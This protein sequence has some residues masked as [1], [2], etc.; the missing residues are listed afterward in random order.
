MTSITTPLPVT[1]KIVVLENNEF[2]SVS[3]LRA[4]TEL[5]N[6]TR[7]ILRGNNIATVFASQSGD[8]EDKSTFQFSRTLT[9]LDVSHNK[10]DSWQF[11]N[12]L[13]T[14]FPGLNSLR[15]SGNPLH[16]RAI[17]PTSVTGLPE[18][19]M[20]V[21]EAFM[22]TLA[23]LENLTSLNYS[24]ITQQD[25]TN[26]EL[27]YLSLIGK[28]ISASSTADEAKILATHPRYSALCEI[29]G[30]P[31]VTRQSEGVQGT[32]IKPGSVAAR[33]VTFDFY[34]SSSGTMSEPAIKSCLIPKTFDTYKI[35]GIVSR[36]FSLAPLRFRL[37]WETEEWDPVEEFNILGGEE[38]DS[39]DEGGNGAE[40]G[41]EDIKNNRG[42]P[43]VV[44]ADGSKFVRRE[45]ELADSTRQVGF[46]FDDHIDKVRVRIERL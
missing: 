17:A 41:K 21:D 44:K 27:Y 33:L 26:G 30:A 12:D 3:S 25:R 45:V 5:S 24:K 7:L 42:E 8:D 40:V 23:R 2:T 31:N 18:K 14:A 6:L 20:T 46:W 43:M 10:I 9:H 36:L 37:V 15:I 19:P 29:Y 11:I 34:Q 16:D 39:D 1:L 22:L 13:A 28:E 4:L 35:K 32:K 38:W